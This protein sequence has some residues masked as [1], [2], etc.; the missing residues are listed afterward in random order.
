MTA[1]AEL[2]TLVSRIIADTTGNDLEEVVADAL[3]DDDLGMSE[4][5]L[6]LV[7]VKLNKELGIHLRLKTVL[8]E[9]I[10]TVGEFTQMVAEESEL[11]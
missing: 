9:G 3:F 10:E 1:A 4:H 6:E 11:G 8:E 7:I 5:E 2:L